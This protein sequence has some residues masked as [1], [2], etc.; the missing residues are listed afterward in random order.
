MPSVS[1]HVVRQLNED[2]PDRTVRIE[3]C[4]QLLA[5]CLHLLFPENA[6]SWIEIVDGDKAV[7]FLPGG[8]MPDSNARS[9]NARI[10]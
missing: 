6:L 9:R 2:V 10:Y 5:N 4:L 1:R 7:R 3:D 8:C